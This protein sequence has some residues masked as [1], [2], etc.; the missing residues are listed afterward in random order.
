MA[1]FLLSRTTTAVGIGLGLS[2]SLHPLSPL[3]ASPMRCQY[4]A[5][6]YRTDSPEGT[7]TGWAI[8]PNDPL[9]HN[10]GKQRHNVSTARTMRQ[11]SL[12]SVLGL[13]AGLG[14]RAFSRVLVVLLG[15]GIVAVEVCIPL[16]QQLSR[17]GDWLL[18]IGSGPRPRGIISFPLIRCRNMPRALMSARP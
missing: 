7:E 5:P 8:D 16:Y 3:R 13:V 11:V 10:Q 9:L 4:T 12:G 1:S 17:W 18:T 2:F 6:Y 15:I 14:L